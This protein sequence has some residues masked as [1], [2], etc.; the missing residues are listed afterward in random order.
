[1][2]RTYI[3]PLGRSPRITLHRGGLPPHKPECVRTHPRSEEA[4]LYGLTIGRFQRL[5][6]LGQPAL[7]QI[8]CTF[9]RGRFG[10]VR[11]PA[12]GS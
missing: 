7:L 6:T 12:L 3:M 10:E 11:P 2:Q 5:E 9:C 4:V 8:G 1:M